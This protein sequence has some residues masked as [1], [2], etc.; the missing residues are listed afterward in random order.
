[1]YFIGVSGLLVLPLSINGMVLLLLLL[2]LLL[3]SLSLGSE[4][5]IFE[6]PRG[7]FRLQEV[8]SR[9]YEWETG[10]S[11]QHHEFLS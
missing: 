5:R 7:K 3:L 9:N 10:A 6:F 4:S 8:G 2:L 11:R 1:M